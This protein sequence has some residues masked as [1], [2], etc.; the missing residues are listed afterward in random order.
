M[1]RHVGIQDTDGH[2]LVV[3]NGHMPER[4]LVTGIGPVRVQQPRVYDRRPGEKFT[5][6]ILP[7]FMRRVPSV[8]A[9]IPCLYFKGISTGYFGEALAAIL[10]PQAAG[11]SATNIVRL[12]DERSCILVVMGATLA[13]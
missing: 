12:E 2:R 4:E 8:D 1:G 11:L 9:L 13:R 5:S 7:P 6:Q 10:G 3:R